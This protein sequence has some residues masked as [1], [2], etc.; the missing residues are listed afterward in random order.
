[1]GKPYGFGHVKIGFPPA[2]AGQPSH[3]IMAWRSQSNA[4]IDDASWERLRKE[5][6]EAFVQQMNDWCQAPE[7]KLGNWA[8]TRQIRA[9]L[10]LAT[11]VEHPD[12]VWPHPLGYPPDPKDF[13]FYKSRESGRLALLPVVESE[14]SSDAPMPRGW[15]SPRPAPTAPATPSCAKPVS[16]VVGQERQVS[17]LRESLDPKRGRYVWFR[18][19]VEKNK[20][21][22][23]AL[24][25]NP[26]S[27]RLRGNLRMGQ[28][29]KLWVAGIEGDAFYLLSETPPDASSRPDAPTAET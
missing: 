3:Q 2:G 16:E 5:S 22:F 18:L 11:P 6:V 20:E 27:P 4:P 24:L 15:D 7:R 19:K 21:K 10:E 14:P 1:M 17:F 8:Q 25:L 26:E 12:H 29:F 23:E 9:L 28:V 13:A